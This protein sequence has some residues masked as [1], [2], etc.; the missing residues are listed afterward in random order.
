HREISAALKAQ[1]EEFYSVLVTVRTTTKVRL[2]GVSSQPRQR[3]RS[4]KTCNQGVP[5]MKVSP[6]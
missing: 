6:S 5:V 2:A 3:P 1:G 4:K